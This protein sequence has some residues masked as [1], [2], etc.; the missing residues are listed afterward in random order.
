MMVAQMLDSVCGDT[1]GI[2]KLGAETIR[3]LQSSLAEKDETIV[4]LR[5]AIWDTFAI[6]GGDTDGDK[7]PNAM[8]SPPL[9]DFIRTFARETRKDYDDACAELANLRARCEAAELDASRYGFLADG[10]DERF[11]VTYWIDNEH[12]ELFCDRERL[13]EAIDAA[14]AAQYA[15]RKEEG[16]VSDCPKICLACRHFY[17]NGGERGYSSMTP[18]SDMQAYC[19]KQH[20][21]AFEETA[22]RFFEDN[23]RAR[24]CP[25]YEVSDLAK[26]H[27]WKNPE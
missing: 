3:A 26:R 15:Q 8:V 2:A 19:A 27:G 21:D 9:P 25:D 18:G 12:Q 1:T 7:T 14:I 10:T 4:A 13:S 22:E 17:F 5:Q 16:K 11:D 6:L 20:W 23:L 24:T